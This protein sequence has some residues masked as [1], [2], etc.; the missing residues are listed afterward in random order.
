M[1]WLKQLRKKSIVELVPFVIILV[2]F[3]MLMFLPVAFLGPWRIL[4]PKAMT[5]LTQDTA[6]G[7]YV[8]TDIPFFYGNFL[9]EVEYEKYSPW[10]YTVLS[11]YYLIDFDDK[12]FMALR[13]YESD[14]EEAE[15]MM[16]QCQKFMESGKPEA[17]PALFRA[18]GSIHA[19]DK[20]ELESYY[21]AVDN[22][23]EI[24]SVML[25]FYLDMGH[26]KGISTVAAVVISGIFLFFGTCL[27]IAGGKVIA[28]AFSGAYQKQLREKLEK[29][30]NFELEAA[31]AQAF[32][33]STDPINGV[34]MNK[35]YI[36]FTDT[37]DV[38]LRP[39][40]IAWVYGQQGKGFSVKLRLMDGTSYSLSMSKKKGE[41]LMRA[42]C[43]IAPGA[44]FGYDEK[45]ALLYKIN[46]QAFANRWAEVLTGG[47]NQGT[48]GKES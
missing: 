24:T 20:E 6:V 32:Y 5:E 7:Q 14:L 27:I 12:Y 47:C 39:W 31:R 29:S 3:G 45:I 11:R 17:V 15:A 21:S 22:D 30:G 35:D 19:M 42:M 37:H 13:V 8:N 2:A 44:V 28:K 10:N 9:D 40:D 38:L 41:Q 33:N 36:F 43:D 48:D 18:K 26:I 23:E 25:P 1:D 4:F 46:R 16:D 34:R